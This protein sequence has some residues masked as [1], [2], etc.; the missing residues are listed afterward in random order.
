MKNIM[1]RLILYIVSVMVLILVI[2]AGGFFYVYHR[3]Q[4]P[5]AMVGENRQIT[6]EK[7]LSIKQIAARL[8]GDGL[9]NSVFY[10]ETYVYFEGIN[11]LQAGDYV[12][13]P[14]MS[15]PEI[16]TALSG[17]LVNRDEVRVTIP[18]G[19]TVKQI[20]ER[21]AQ[22]GLI[23]PG[24]L[25]NFDA[26][27]FLPQPLGSNGYHRLV[28]EEEGYLFPD[29]YIFDRNSSAKDIWQKMYDNFNKKVAFEMLTE[30]LGQRR[31]LYDIVILASIVQQEA[32]ITE[33][34]PR[35]AGVFYNRL[36]INMPLQSDATVNYITG[37][38]MRRAS[39]ED[40]KIDSS[41]NTYKYK[42]LPPGP[43]CNPGLDAIMAAIWPEKSDYYYFLHPLNAPTVFSK[44]EAEHRANKAKWLE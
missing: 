5:A 25:L 34:M 3:I 27:P 36:A 37:K 2:A 22:F 39:M 4:T 29:T 23:K 35:I 28:S 11:S 8:E 13:N 42:G 41:Y 32:S 30:I 33:E 10:F 7:G 38:G 40:T 31:S 26:G 18:E 6:I 12:L 21:L 14:S 19:F 15:I 1:R 43:I 24:E 20:D 9:I 44:T 16:A 17:G